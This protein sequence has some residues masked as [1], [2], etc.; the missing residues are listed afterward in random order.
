MERQ[1]HADAVRRGSFLL[2]HLEE[3]ELAIADGV[4]V[5]GYFH[6]SLLDNFEWAEGYEPRFGLVEVDFT[7][8]ERRPRPSA[9]LYARIARERTTRGPVLSPGTTAAT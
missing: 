4:D 8:Q 1:H 7:T 9:G 3:L 6:W 5:R 2:R